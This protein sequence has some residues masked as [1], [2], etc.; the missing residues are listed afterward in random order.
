M[1]APTAAIC[2]ALTAVALGLAGL[3]FVPVGVVAEAVP[4]GTIAPLGVLQG[5]PSLTP[6]QMDRILAGYGSPAAGSGQDFYNLGVQYSI[7]PAY[8]L[9]FFVEES[10]AGTDPQWDGIKPDGSTT[11]DIGNISCA[12]YP[13]CY[14]RWRDYPDWRTGIDDWF[15][16]I[17]VEYIQQRG[18]TTVD[19]VIPVYAPAF[20]NDVGGYTNTVSALVAKW[21]EE[22]QG[23]SSARVS[24]SACPV[25]PCWQSGTGYEPGHPGIDLGT[26]LG[27]PVYATMAGT[28]RNSATWPCGN[29]VMVTQGDWATLA[30]H[31]S[32]FAV[33]DGA[34][35][36]AG[37]VV[38][39]AG[40][41]G[42]S[43]GPHVHFERRYKGGNVNPLEE[44]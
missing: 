43:T 5:P 6:A 32:G 12:G 9:A 18:H 10:S 3:F 30:C 34:A 4:S 19:Q 41:S 23:E 1:S 33:G 38:G 17:S 8:A 14:G 39:S 31:L 2:G 11:H 44:H 13:T 37:A 24:S 26:T 15:R 20:E 36:E 16:L 35:V 22:T 42:E 29:G 25:D 40:S 27:Q 28:V 7:D 21:R